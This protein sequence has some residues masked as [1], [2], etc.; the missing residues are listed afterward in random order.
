[1]LYGG[2]LAIKIGI[3][4]KMNNIHIR[5][6]TKKSNQVIRE[7]KLCPRCDSIHIRKRTR[8]HGYRC[9]TCSHVFCAPK[10]VSMG[11]GNWQV[12]KPK[13]DNKQ[14]NP[15]SADKPTLWQE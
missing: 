13:L 3:V 9:D 10:T 14:S 15:N 8:L 1:M 6:K 12:L 2:V 4:L 7:R 11:H 5:K